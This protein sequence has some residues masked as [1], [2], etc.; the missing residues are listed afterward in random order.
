M[1]QKKKY[2]L[3]L[4]G[5][6]LAIILVHSFYRDSQLEKQYPP[7]LRNRIVGARLQK[8]G[9]LPYNYFYDPAD[10]WRYFDPSNHALKS[11]GCNNVTASP[12]FHELLM[13][14]CELPE[15]TLS[16][17]W[18]WMEYLVLVIIAGLAIASTQD[19]IKRWLII[20]VAVL[21]TT[22][23][24]WIVLIERG[25][26]YL[27]AALLLSLIF[28]LM[29]GR[30][31][32][33]PGFA[34]L[35][36]VVFI[37]IRPIGLVLLIPFL[38][39][40]RKYR[41]FLL[42]TVAALGV[43]VLFVLSS[44]WEKSLYS[45]YFSNMQLQVLAHQGLL[46]PAG[47]QEFNMFE[48]DLEGYDYHEVLLERAKHPI[49]TYS[50]NGNIFEFY[51]QA[52]GEYIPL[53]LL[54]ALFAGSLLILTAAFWYRHRN[55]PADT[56]LT[57]LF[58]MVLYI[59]TEIFSPVNRH[60]YYTVEWFPIVL[61]SIPLLSGH[62]RMVA[63]LLFTGLLLNICNISWIPMRHTLGEFCWVA[64]ILMLTRVKPAADQRYRSPYL[65]NE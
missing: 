8:D 32:F 2:L 23:E 24:A 13:P 39:A 18:M 42:T 21:F 33:A 62:T 57:L 58:G 50:E 20:N 48:A 60:Q 51:L 45:N 34:G 56:S 35:L 55:H 3:W 31:K 5:I 16:R 10:G 46:P 37:L 54:N 63:W 6:L 9:I 44:P 14:F 49:V 29:T 47:R 40:F 11:S 19:N 64:A 65:P 15:R 36:T 38:P 41:V 43:Y 59:V 7:D 61:F 4:N 52:T 17:M 12:F 53:P 26:L 30:R 22:T 25:Q 28:F 1:S 27:F